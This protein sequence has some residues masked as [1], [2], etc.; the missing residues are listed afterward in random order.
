MNTLI[1]FLEENNVRLSMGDRWLCVEKEHDEERTPLYTVY[2]RGV[3][4]RKTR[5]LYE[6]HYLSTALQFLKGDVE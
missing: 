3:G 2:H 1:E 4:T 6:G 5:T